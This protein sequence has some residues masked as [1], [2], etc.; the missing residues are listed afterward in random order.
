MVANGGSIERSWSPP[1]IRLDSRWSG[2]EQRIRNGRPASAIESASSFDGADEIKAKTTI[3]LN[4]VV[5]NDIT[6]SLGDMLLVTSLDA[7]VTIVNDDHEGH[8]RGR[9]RGQ[10]RRA[11]SY[12]VRQLLRRQIAHSYQNLCTEG[13]SVP[14]LLYIF[15]RS[16]QMLILSTNTHRQESGTWNHENQPCRTYFIAKNAKKC[17]FMTKMNTTLTPQWLMIKTISMTQD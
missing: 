1:S 7:T 17:I 9:S 8:R 3:F 11:L 10:R 16:W 13:N 14:T 5:I 6:F 2:G 15:C 4:L 12:L